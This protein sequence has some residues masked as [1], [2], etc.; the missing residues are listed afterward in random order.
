M[1]PCRPKSAVDIE[2]NAFSVC[3]ARLERLREIFSVTPADIQ[4]GDPVWQEPMDIWLALD[5]MN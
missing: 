3:P 1:H 5:A 2:R 4:R